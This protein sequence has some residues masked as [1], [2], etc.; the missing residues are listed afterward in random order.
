MILTIDKIVKKYHPPIK[1]LP[2]RSGMPNIATM[3]LFASSFIIIFHF[4]I[5]NVL[6]P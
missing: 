5:L 6:L 2:I 1:A 3:T 4:R